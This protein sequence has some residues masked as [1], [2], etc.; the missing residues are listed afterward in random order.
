MAV[1]ETLSRLDGQPVVMILGAGHVQNNMGVYERV[2]HQ[3]PGIRQLNL[4]FREVAEAPEP[5]QAYTQP[6]EFD[7]ATF[8]PDHEYL[9]FSRRA[10]RD[11]DDLCKKFRKHM[12]KKQS[13]TPA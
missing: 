2:A 3:K 4:G 10:G 13:K 6:L 8:D 11:V 1:V 5:L 12:Q 9:W 7:G